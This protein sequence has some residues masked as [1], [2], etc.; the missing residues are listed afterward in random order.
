MTNSI[1]TIKLTVSEA[2]WLRNALSI[3]SSACA[4]PAPVMAKWAHAFA[5]G[6]DAQITKRQEAQS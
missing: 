6:L 3:A 1:I 2:E 4:E 5:L